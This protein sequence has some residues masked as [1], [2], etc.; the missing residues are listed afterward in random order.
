ME[1]MKSGGRTLD[2]IPSNAVFRGCWQPGDDDG[3]C[4]HLPPGNHVCNGG[5]VKAC[6]DAALT[7]WP[8]SNSVH[9][10]LGVLLALIP[11]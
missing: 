5:K 2:N 8:G 3:T 4:D 7:G 1:L 6:F 11:S 9:A 10:K